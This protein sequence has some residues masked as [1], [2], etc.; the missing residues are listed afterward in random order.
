MFTILRIIVTLPT[1]SKNGTIGEVK[2][3]N[4]ME[5][6]HRYISTQQC[7]IQD[8]CTVG[9]VYPKND[10]RSRSHVACYFNTQVSL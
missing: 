5:S 3:Q 4:K 6:A 9:I 7:Q 2:Q 10:V 1:G 8:I